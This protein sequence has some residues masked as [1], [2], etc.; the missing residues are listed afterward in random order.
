MLLTTG[1]DS[2]AGQGWSQEA[3]L[4][5]MELEQTEAVPSQVHLRK[6][7]LCLSLEAKPRL[8]RARCLQ[9]SPTKV[10][11]S[12]MSVGVRIRNRNSVMLCKQFLFLALYGECH[13][14]P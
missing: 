10:H 13:V 9:V 11:F 14:Y 3:S 5:G 8:L 1:T 12:S 2:D 6:E 7:G 4:E